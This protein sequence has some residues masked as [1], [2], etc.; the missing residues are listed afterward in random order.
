MRSGRKEKEGGREGGR[1]DGLTYRDA[2]VG[3]QDV[4]GCDEVPPV[5]GGER[6]VEDGEENGYFNVFSCKHSLI[7]HPPLPPA[8]PSPSVLGQIGDEGTGSGSFEAHGVPTP[9]LRL[10]PHFAGSLGGKGGGKVKRMKA[11]FILPSAHGE[12]LLQE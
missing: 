12:L 11:S 8:L 2:E 5:C 10:V 3:G 9:G 4:V 6:E 1:E 7:L